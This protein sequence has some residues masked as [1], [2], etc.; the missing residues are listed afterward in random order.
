VDHI[1]AFDDD[2]PVELIRALRPD[3]YAKGGDYRLDR[4]P[5][6]PL[7]QEL[8]GEVRILPFV[9]DRSTSGIIER[10]GRSYVPTFASVGASAGAPNEP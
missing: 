2:S 9:D 3:V 7:V 1:V 8:G 4:L 5:E 6:A 10:I